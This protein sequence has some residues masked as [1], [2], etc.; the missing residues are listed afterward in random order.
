MPI[1]ADKA[2]GRWRYT[3]NRIIAGQRQRSTKLL[4]KGWT[5]AQAHT[6]DQEESRRL[7]D[8]TAGIREERP[9]ALIEAAVSIY[10]E[11][12]IPSLK[13]GKKQ[14][15]EFALIYWAYKGR[16]LDELAEVGREYI[17]KESGN[18]QPATIRNRL[19]YLRAACRYAFKTHHLCSHDPAERLRMPVVRNERHFYLK[20]KT[21]L[22]I[23]MKLKGKYRA[24]VR[25]AFYSG[26]RLS[27]ILKCKFEDGR[28]TLD[29]T[30]NGDRRIVPMHR[31]IKSCAKYLP[32]DIPAR[33]LQGQFNQARKSLDLDHIHI[34][35]L[36]HSAAS[37][38]INNGVDLYT[39]GAV[40]GHKSMVS[41]KR[42]SH[43][44][45]STLETALS[46]IGQKMHTRHE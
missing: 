16:Y 11:E 33:T 14:L 29:D 17:A 8:I 45:T 43:L 20:R 4:P 44:A 22:Q 37:E 42:Y 19:A 23:A 5:K 27:E 36:R 31:K 15:G 26:M 46:K 7:S 25:I 39:V 2:S 1:S 13:H 40:L 41:T 9:R 38:M 24:A 3:F 6:Y 18:L 34:H 28:M 12:R 32:F 21:M 35:D 30:K 10:C